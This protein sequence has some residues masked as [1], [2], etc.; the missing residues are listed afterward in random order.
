MRKDEFTSSSFEPRMQDLHSLKKKEVF[1][2]VVFALLKVATNSMQ[3][4]LLLNG[5]PTHHFFG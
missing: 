1:G 2:E 3:Q 5:D 4:A